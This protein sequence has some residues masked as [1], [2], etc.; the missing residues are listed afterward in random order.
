M[1]IIEYDIR[2]GPINL[3]VSSDC[4]WYRWA[5]CLNVFENVFLFYGGYQ[6]INI[7]LISVLYRVGCIEP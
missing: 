7:V 3:P 5:V 6:V 2:S 1:A 4:T